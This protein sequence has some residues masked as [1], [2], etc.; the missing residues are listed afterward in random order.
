MN[1]PIVSPF[2]IYLIG[3]T[4]GITW[5]IVMT[6]ILLFAYNLFVGLYKGSRDPC[7]DGIPYGEREEVR[8]SYRKQAAEYY[9]RC[10]TWGAIIVVGVVLAGLL[11][12]RATLIGMVVANKVTPTT[13]DKTGAWVE[14]QRE[15]F[16]Q[17]LIDII[18]A[19]DDED[20]QVVDPNE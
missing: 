1:D 10:R 15:V 4:G 19:I 2:W 18:N 20:E 16:K 8:N 3:N 6:P 9:Q 14:S 5:A 13:I 17:D 12:D 7:D 11:P